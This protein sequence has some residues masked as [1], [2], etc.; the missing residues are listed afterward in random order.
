MDE[1]LLFAQTEPARAPTDRLFFGLFPDA[2]TAARLARL[3]QD[4]RRTHGLNGRPLEARRFHVTLSHLGD[5]A[6][7]PQNIVAAA[8]EAASKVSTTI[9]DVEFDWAASF[10]GKPGNLPF[11]LRAADGNDALMDF[12]RALCVEMIKAGVRYKG[13]SMFTPHVTLLYDAVSVPRQ[14]IEPIRWIVRE[15]VLIRSLL[16]QTKHIALERWS[17]C[18][19]AAP[20]RL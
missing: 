3:A 2:E 1:P 14:E 15:F 20:N 8:I 9:F 5:F 17:L 7:L 16:G 19:S 13:G 6:G 10:S 18:A 12:Q 11:V 4:L